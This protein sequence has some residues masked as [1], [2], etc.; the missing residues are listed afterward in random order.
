MTV[1]K[2]NQS[3]IISMYKKYAI[4]LHKDTDPSLIGNDSIGYFARF[5]SSEKDRS[6]LYSFFEIPEKSRFYFSDTAEDFSNSSKSVVASRII[7]KSLMK[8][9]KELILYFPEHFLWDKNMSVYALTLYRMTHS[10]E[11]IN[12]FP[13]FK[14]NLFALKE[15]GQI[16][17]VF[18]L[19]YSE[20]INSSQNNTDFLFSKESL[21]MYR[22]E[23]K[24]NL[25]AQ[26]FIKDILSILMKEIRS[27]TTSTYKDIKVEGFF[28]NK[29]NEQKDKTIFCLEEIKNIISTQGY[30]RKRKPKNYSRLNKE[31]FK[32][33]FS[34]YVQ[35]HM[36][37][38][39][40]YSNNYD[41][42]IFLK[43][44]KIINTLFFPSQI[45][46]SFPGQKNESL[47]G[48]IFKQYSLY[49]SHILPHKGRFDYLELSPAKD[50]QEKYL[51]IYRDVEFLKN[52]V[53]KDLK[54]NKESEYAKIDLRVLNPKRY[55]Y[56]TKKNIQ[57]ALTD[58]IILDKQ[59]KSDMRERE[60]DEL[61][62]NEYE[63]NILNYFILLVDNMKK[64]GV[65]EKVIRPFLTK[66]FKLEKYITLKYFKHSGESLFID[67]E[68]LHDVFTTLLP[69]IKKF[70]LVYLKD[71]LFKDSDFINSF[72][73]IL[74]T[75]NLDK[76]S[77][78]KIN[79]EINNLIVYESEIKN[80]QRDGKLFSFK[81]LYELETVYT[82]IEE[83]KYKRTLG[84]IEKRLKISSKDKSFV[85]AEKM[86]SKIEYLELLSNIVKRKEAVDNFKKE[87]IAKEISIKR[88]RYSVEILAHNNPIGLLGANVGVCISASGTH[89]ISQINPNFSNL[90]VT[91]NQK[92]I[93]WGLLCR[94]VD[95]NKNIY[96]VLNNLQGSIN[97]KRINSRSVLDD[98]YSVFDTF[99]KDSNINTIL[100]RNNG[101][102]A[103]KLEGKH[104]SSDEIISKKI[105]LLNKIRLDFIY[106]ENGV[107]ADDFYSR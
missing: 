85:V 88:E 53:K 29:R 75:Y 33:C 59:V 1:I 69:T 2:C 28:E 81:K 30:L 56:K 79:K 39:A 67:S 63:G 6:L 66:F 89:R 4:H 26:Y 14:K 47:V 104:Y 91:D 64:V 70:S 34:L 49:V 18:K 45:K 58:M 101:F 32:A 50:I 54:Y 23:N 74:I 82:E 16:K 84:I 102:N 65:N 11:K 9:V 12:K 22:K 8:L 5:F 98:I 61:N 86:R 60:I 73:K 97:D 35:K 78:V 15:D 94:C 52:A 25:P 27:G 87:L 76:E 92:I 80:R 93:L 36:M 95:S 71:N 44:Q 62:K 3:H 37:S 21:V 31:N 51:L 7:E 99:K 13:S 24:G 46:K 83:E 68:L 42:F 90:I 55:A 57:D 19:G 77:I 107:L 38:R 10:I 41:F 43:E 20:N 48:N 17:G 72:F 103:L 40:P 100:F 106:D 96:Y 105:T